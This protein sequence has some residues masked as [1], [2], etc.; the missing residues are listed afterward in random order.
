MPIYE[1]TCTNETCATKTEKLISDIN[2][3]P[4]TIECPACGAESK[5]NIARTGAP[6]FKGRGFYVTD[7]K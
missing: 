6:Q 1:Y 7:Y 5:R 2:Y 3:R 4:E